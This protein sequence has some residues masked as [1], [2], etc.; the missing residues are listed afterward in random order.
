MTAAQATATRS[1][2]YVAAIGEALRQAMEA[3]PNVFLAGEDVALYGGVFGTSRGL[4]EKFGPQRVVD[5]PIAES[6]LMGL[7]LGSA[8]TGLRPVI[9]I[10]FMDFLGV[11]MD[12]IVNQVAK[13]K[14]MFGGKATLPLT[15]RT[16]AGGGMSMAA[17]HSQNLE[18]W[19]CHVP[20]LKVVM[21][22]GPYEAKGLL[23]AAI[24]DDN[25]VI[26]VEN[27]LS[28]GMQAE[29]PEEMYEIPLGKANVVR[30]GSNFTILA[31]GRMVSESLKAAE[32]LA[33]EGVD[34]E[35]I[36]PRTLQPFDVETV[37][38]SVKKTHR[39]LV[40]HEAVRFGGIGAEFAAQIQEEAFDY[41]DAP[42]GRVGAP[43][44]PVPFAPNLEKLY[45]PDAGKIADGVRRVLG[46]QV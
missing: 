30:P 45:V 3:D 31:T 6:G 40:A 28:L 26:V 11:C 22:S 38:E 34:C 20:G 10:M 44:S 29:V 16:M 27:K 25:P 18:A 8:A 14:Y 21:P 42:V 46:K 5:T 12:E 2:T 33:G 43:F 15:I 7:G 39:V 17:Q 13:M 37:V 24:R 35:V 41:L 23:I 32:T 9:E 4:M 1:I 19:F 36:D